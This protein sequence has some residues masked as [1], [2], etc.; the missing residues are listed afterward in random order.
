MPN[1]IGGAYKGSTNTVPPDKPA[2]AFQRPVSDSTVSVISSRVGVVRDR[3]R[4]GPT[5]GDGIFVDQKDDIPGDQA[6]A[7]REN[8]V[9]KLAKFLKVHPADRTQQYNR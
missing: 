5:T 7:T 8:N 4:T 9:L 6:T 1:I 3:A 2:A